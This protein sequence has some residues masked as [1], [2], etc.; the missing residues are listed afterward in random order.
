MNRNIMIVMAGGFLIAIL[1]AVLVQASLSGG[2]KQAAQPAVKQEP[3]VEVAVAGKNLEKGDDLEEG[4][5]RWQSWP[6]SGVFEGMVIREEGKKPL[7]MLSGRLTMDVTAGQPVLHSMVVTSPGINL[8][9]ALE[10]S[11]RAITVQLAG[12]AMVGGFAQPGDYVDV[13]LTYKFQESVSEEI[14]VGQDTEVGVYVAQ[15]IDKYA[16]EVIIEN[17]KVLAVDQRA[18]KDEE[19]AKVGRMVTL[20]VTQRDAEAIRVADE[21]G[22]I[23]LA[24][25]P[26]GDEERVARGPITTDM[27]VVSVDDE[28][29][30][31]ILQIY[32]DT[33]EQR[34]LRRGGALAYPQGMGQNNTGQ[35]SNIVRIY[36]GD[37]VED[38]SVTP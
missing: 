4:T 36:R 27:R 7:E 3:R 18:S 31:H 2:R 38:L 11:M 5:L 35:T 17:I 34:M 13:L 22:K 10:P 9:A 24:L 25:R 16:A 15:N 26:L 28:I 21:I 29:Y 20:Q 14:D 12:A 8:A 37:Q 19:K 6:K 32:E 33:I 30:S 23:S 1:V